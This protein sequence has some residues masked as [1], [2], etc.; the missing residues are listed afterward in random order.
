MW[1]EYY[2]YIDKAIRHKN[3]KISQ[4]EPNIIQQFLFDSIPP[5]NSL[6]SAFDVFHAG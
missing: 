4:I 1:V 2:G 3:F 5:A 6:R